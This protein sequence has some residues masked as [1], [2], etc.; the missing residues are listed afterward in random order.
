MKVC[1]SILGIWFHSW[2]RDVYLRRHS[3]NSKSFQ[4]ILLLKTPQS[5]N[6]IKRFSW[7]S[8]FEFFSPTFHYSN[9]THLVSGSSLLHWT[10]SFWVPEI[11]KYVSVLP[12]LT[13]SHGFQKP[14]SVKLLGSV[15]TFL[16]NVFFNVVMK[17]MYSGSSE[18]AY[19]GDG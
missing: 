3:M 14:A 11:W 4:S 6:P 9:Q 15:C 2:P 10:L 5:G 12:S 8:H 7:L 17:G 18:C 19:L 13:N 16:P 1:K